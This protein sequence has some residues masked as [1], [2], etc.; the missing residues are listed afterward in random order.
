MP[1]E[2][3][4]SKISREGTGHVTDSQYTFWTQNSG[5]IPWLAVLHVL[6][7]HI[8]AEGNKHC[9]HKSTGTRQLEALQ[10]ISS[11]PCCIYLF[12]LLIYICIPL[13]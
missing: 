9:P 11:V 13:L 8:I 6:L 3:L 10:L 5:E 1:P 4:E 7:L 2:K 12:S